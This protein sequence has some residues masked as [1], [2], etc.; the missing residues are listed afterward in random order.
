MARA[1]HPPLAWL[2]IAGVAFQLDGVQVEEG[3]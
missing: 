3:L 1:R 2:R